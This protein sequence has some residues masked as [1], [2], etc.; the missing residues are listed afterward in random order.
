MPG[1]TFSFKLDDYKNTFIA[2]IIQSEIKVNENAEPDKQSQFW[3]MTLLHVERDGDKWV[4]MPGRCIFESNGNARCPLRDIPTLA[5]YAETFHNHQSIWASTSPMSQA[6]R[7]IDSIQ[8]KGHYTP[9]SAGDVIGKRYQFEEVVEK[10][11][12][13]KSDGK[14]ITPHYYYVSG[15]TEADNPLTPPDELPWAEMAEAPAVQTPMETA[16]DNV[17]A[18]TTN[19]IVDVESLSEDDIDRWVVALVNGKSE[20]A[21][22]VAIRAET[23]LSNN[24]KFGLRF[25]HGTYAKGAVEKGYLALSNGVFVATDKA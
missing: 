19:G 24:P 9:I 13:R 21:A 22:K 1:Q 3:N 18:A 17:S 20:D 5:H 10:P 2:E 16:V 6:F 8:Q 23:S 12:Q 11:Y 14:T 15:E 7:F 25:I 4:S